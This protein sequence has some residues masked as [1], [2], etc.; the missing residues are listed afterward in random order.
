MMMFSVSVPE[1][2]DAL[3]SATAA[4]QINRKPNSDNSGKL[5]FDDIG[6]RVIRLLGA[7]RR[8]YITGDDN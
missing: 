3:N 7:G 5:A 4:H 8:L 1:D 6:N 2:Y